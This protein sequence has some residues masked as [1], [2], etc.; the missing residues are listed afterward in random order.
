MLFSQEWNDNIACCGAS[1]RAQGSLSHASGAASSACPF[2][3]DGGGGGSAGSSNSP[4]LPALSLAAHAQASQAQAIQ[5]QAAA[6]PNDCNCEELCKPV[7]QLFLPVRRTPYSSRPTRTNAAVVY[8]DGLT[9]Q[10]VKHV[11]DMWVLVVRWQ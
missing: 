7:H 3:S 2:Q 9:P 8:L 6:L 11:K 1:S 5:A 4:A 10:Q